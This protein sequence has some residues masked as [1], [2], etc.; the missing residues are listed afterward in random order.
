MSGDRTAERRA[1]V[2]SEAVS[3]RDQT[4]KRKRKG[5][6][7]KTTVKKEILLFAID[8]VYFISSS[9]TINCGMR[10]SLLFRQSSSANDR[11]QQGAI[12]RKTIYG[13][14]DRR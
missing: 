14:G 3:D 4:R 9:D 8:I 6:R 10:S 13:Y 2:C 5:K 11:L 1:R 7:K 12:D